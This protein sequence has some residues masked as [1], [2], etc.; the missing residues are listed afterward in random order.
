MN[1]DERLAK[2]EHFFKEVVDLTV[3]HEVIGDTAVVYP[4]A[5]G[6]SL[7]R[8]APDWVLRHSRPTP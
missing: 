2:L 8:V 4:S 5:L 3:G 7:S 1:T 6:E